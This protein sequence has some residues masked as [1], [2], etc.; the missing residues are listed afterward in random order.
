MLSYNNCQLKYHGN[1]KYHNIAKHWTSITV[2]HSIE[3]VGL[4]Y[5]ANEIVHML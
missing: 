3:M 2:K 5:Y 4:L 1:C